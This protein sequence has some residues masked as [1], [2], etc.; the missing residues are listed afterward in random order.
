[1]EASRLRR[2]DCHLH[3][4]A[5]S[6][7]TVADARY[8]PDYAAALD[9]WRRLAVAAG[10]GRGVLVQPSFLGCDN[11]R[12][13]ASLAT[14]P[15]ALRGIAVLAPD[16]PT[17]AIA[18]LAG[19]GIV[20]LRLNLY[21]RLQWAAELRRHQPLLGRI[22]DAGWHLELHLP[23]GAL[24]DALSWLPPTLGLVL[25]HFGRP[26]AT[27]PT[28]LAALA[29]RPGRV[30]VKLS[31]P[32]RLDAAVDLQAWIA[33]WTRRF[34]WSGLLWGSDWPWT[35]HEREA[36]YPALLDRLE[37]WCAGDAAALRAVL[38]DNPARL[39]GFDEAAGP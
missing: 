7:P 3:V 24:A 14:A 39:Y 2:T 22:A 13:L 29:D 8:R 21:G 33:A 35:R 5:P 15:Q 11:G 26:A 30:W 19:R 1:M 32:Y 31:A 12:L 20:G 25:D 28:P 36:D 9:D 16:A 27:A 4:F 17:D 10:V 18:A 6:D 37:R 38:V 34:G 23:D